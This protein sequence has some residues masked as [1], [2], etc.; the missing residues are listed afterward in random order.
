MAWVL[1]A[2]TSL[3]S[4]CKPQKFWTEKKTFPE[5]EARK[6][7]FPFVRLAAHVSQGCKSQIRPVVGRI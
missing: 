5:L 6:G 7:F 3:G 2:E 1:E 4:P